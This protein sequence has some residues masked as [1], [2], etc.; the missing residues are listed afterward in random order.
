MYPTLHWAN[1]NLLYKFIKELWSSV[2]ISSF[3]CS[4]LNTQSTGYVPGT[5]LVPG[6][7]AINKQFCLLAV[8]KQIG[9]EE[10]A[11]NCLLTV[12]ESAVKRKEVVGISSGSLALFRL[13]RVFLKR[14]EQGK[15]IPG[16][17]SN[18]RLSQKH[19]RV[20]VQHSGF[21]AEEHVRG[22]LGDRE[23]NSRIR[24]GGVSVLQDAQ[25]GLR[26]LK[27]E[28]SIVCFHISVGRCPFNL[29]NT[30]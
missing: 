25:C 27:T 10:N 8:H 16:R 28:S 11:N 26:L 7:M 2:C 18:M 3:I 1:S 9:Q 23:G 19:T 15:G 21:S 13:I 4:L 12:V 14:K 22:T 24:S 30:Y 6:D 20:C 29:A 17:E 5:I